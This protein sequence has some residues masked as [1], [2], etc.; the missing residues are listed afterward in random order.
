MIRS[1]YIFLLSMFFLVISS[2]SSAVMDSS[3]SYSTGISGPGVY[4]VWV[5]SPSSGSYLSVPFTISGLKGSGISVVRVNNKEAIISGSSWS[6]VMESAD[7][8]GLGLLDFMVMGQKSDGTFIDELH[9]LWNVTNNGITSQA[10]TVSGY[11]TGAYSTGW[12]IFY[13]QGTGAVPPSPDGYAYMN[14]SNYSLTV[15]TNYG[16]LRLYAYFDQSGNGIYDPAAEYCYTTISNL[17]II[18]NSISNYDVLLPATAVGAL[19]GVLSNNTWGYRIGVLAIISNQALVFS[20]PSYTEQSYSYSVEIK[21]ATGDLIRLGYYIDLDGDNRWDYSLVSGQSEPYYYATAYVFG[22][23]AV[24]DLILTPKS[25]NGTVTGD[26]GGLDIISIKPDSGAYFFK[27]SVSGGIFSLRYYVVT[28]TPAFSIST[29]N[30]EVI[31]FDDINSDGFYNPSE[32]GVMP[33]NIIEVSGGAEPSTN[34]LN[35][36]VFSYTFTMIV[37]GDD[38]SRFKGARSYKGG[39]E[40][41]SLPGTWNLYKWAGTVESIDIYPYRDDN[42]NNVPDADEFIFRK[43]I[44]I[45]V[46]NLPA[47]TNVYDFRRTVLSVDALYGDPGLYSNPLMQYAVGNNNLLSYPATGC[48]TNY[49]DTNSGG[50]GGGSVKVFDDLDG[51][52]QRNGAEPWIA[53]NSLTWAVYISNTNTSLFLTN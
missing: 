52:G 49:W 40:S 26:N 6:V 47:L 43:G 22:G 51:N 5:T 4:D 18:S 14:G 31:I 34:I 2:C 30:S 15:A 46:S 41:K 32:N 39:E 17:V 50:A 9:C 44:S 16:N 21:A 36:S 28:D 3:S 33:T 13:S 10:Y 8:L 38:S 7:S 35:F 19:T 27:Q 42:N 37:S 48:Y 24:K 23:P 53:T 29:N 20:S 11:L 25:L 1:S 12:K 45:V